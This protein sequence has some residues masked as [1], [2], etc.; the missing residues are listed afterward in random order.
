MSLV[1]AIKSNEKIYRALLEAM[2]ADMSSKKSFI[3]TLLKN[4]DMIS[5]L[6]IKEEIKRNISL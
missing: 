5:E 1:K 6:S 2:L 4:P 3:M